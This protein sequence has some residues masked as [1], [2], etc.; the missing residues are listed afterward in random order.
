MGILRQIERIKCEILEVVGF[1]LQMARPVVVLLEFQGINVYQK[2][3]N[4]HIRCR[5]ESSKAV[6]ESTKP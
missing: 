1:I 6:K 5:C 3:K 4:I 2:K